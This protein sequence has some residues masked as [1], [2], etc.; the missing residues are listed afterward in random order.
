MQMEMLGSE[1][2]RAS[3]GA[4]IDKAHAGTEIVVERHKRPVVSVVN[5]DWLQQ[6]KARLAWL[7][8]HQ[9]SVLAAQ[10]FEEL[11]ISDA[12]TYT[13]AELEALYDDDTA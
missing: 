7:E 1:T 5:H 9:R 12:P 4:T 6:V 2:V 10:A 8:Q 11:A 13:F 3:W